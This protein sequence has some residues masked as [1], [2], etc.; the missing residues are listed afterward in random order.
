MALTKTFDA[1][2]RATADE[3]KD[4]AK[5]TPLSYIV[6]QPNLTREMLSLLD[7][8]RS[9]QLLTWTAQV[10]DY[11]PKN[12]PIATFN[13]EVPLIKLFNFT[14]YSKPLLPCVRMPEDGILTSRTEIENLF[15]SVDLFAYRPLISTAEAD[16][17]RNASGVSVL[18]E[19]EKTQ[20]LE[21]T[22]LYVSLALNLL[23]MREN[24]NITESEANQ[25]VA[26]QRDQMKPFVSVSSA[27]R[28]L[29]PGQ[30]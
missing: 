22:Y 11:V 3:L 1:K 2:A 30:G 14:V 8:H 18:Q 10:D 6:S 24:R 4:R 5:Y 21:A 15:K 27:T 12:K 9:G 16:K 17:H 23:K 13:L 26:Y 28:P 19:L 20:N 25:Y 29:P 7:K